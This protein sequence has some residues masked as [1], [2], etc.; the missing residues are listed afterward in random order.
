MYLEFTI[1]FT[2]YA[3]QFIACYRKMIQFK[4]FKVKNV[5]W[6]DKLTLQSYS[7]PHSPPPPQKKTKQNNLKQTDQ[8]KNKTKQK[9]K[10]E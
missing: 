7:D 9:T 10:L 6:I 4:K 8:K 2:N 1:K 3:Q 5:K